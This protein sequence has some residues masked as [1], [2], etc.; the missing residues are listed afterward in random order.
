MLFLGVR[1]TKLGEFPY[2]AS[3]PAQAPLSHGLLLGSRGASCAD[4]SRARTSRPRSRGP[5]EIH[6]HALPGGLGVVRITA[7]CRGSRAGDAGQRAQATAPA[8]RWQRTWISAA[9]AAQ[10]VLDAV[11][12]PGPAPRRAPL[13]RARRG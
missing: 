8:A 9:R 13:M 3:A 2:T 5:V 6:R 10:H 4:S 11:S 12:N 1:Q 7:R